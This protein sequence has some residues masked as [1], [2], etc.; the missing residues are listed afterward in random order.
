[1]KKTGI[2]EI[3]QVALVI[4]VIIILG[5]MPPIP[6]VL[7]PVPLVLQNFGIMIAG[8]LLGP[9]KGT[10]AIGGFLFL[11]FLGFPILSGGQGG[12]AVFVSASGGYLIGW[13]LTPL[14]IGL[15]LSNGFLRK[16][17]LTQLMAVWFT[18]V[19]IVDLIGS[20][21]LSVITP[22]PFWA[23]AVS[24]LVFIPGDTLKAIGAYWIAERVR[25]PTSLSKVQENKKH[26]ETN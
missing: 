1:M 19:L 13:L 4:A 7:I 22:M 25:M 16:R 3:T 26:G 14:L 17:R 12:P 18:A 2:K 11:V 8:L 6:L 20:I 23:S 9:K 10:I 24:N 21:W 15:G 5:L